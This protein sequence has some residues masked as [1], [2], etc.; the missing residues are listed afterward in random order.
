M[1]RIGK[2]QVPIPQGVEAVCADGVLTIK[3]P[4]GTLSRPIHSFFTCKI[5][6]FANDGI[7]KPHL[8]LAR[9]SIGYVLFGPFFN[10]DS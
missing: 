2:K 4:K 8:L 5:A 10:F 3:G 6:L 7:G 1:S 9:V